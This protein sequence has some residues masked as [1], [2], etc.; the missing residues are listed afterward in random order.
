MYSGIVTSSIVVLL[1][2]YLSGCLK[3]IKGVSV[4]SVL[5]KEVGFNLHKKT[6]PTP[7]Q[8]VLGHC[9]HLPP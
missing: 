7:K 5:V 9:E 3:V 8:C 6:N 2:T 4:Q 1:H